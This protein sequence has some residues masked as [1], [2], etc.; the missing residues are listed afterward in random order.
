MGRPEARVSSAESQSAPAGKYRVILRS[1]LLEL[2][3]VVE[4]R[5]ILHVDMDAFFASVEQ[6]DHPELRG[7]PV[8]VGYA[9][10][11]GV[12]AAASY[13]ARTFGCRSAQPMSVALRNCPHA[14]VMPVRFARYGQVSDQV[15]AI[16]ESCSSLVEPLS[17]DEAFM[18]VTAS[19]RLLGEPVQIARRIKA[20]IRAATGL[21]A[22]VGVSCNKFLA[23]LASDLHKPDGLTV[24]AGGEAQRILAPM[25]VTRLWGVGPKTAAQLAGLG[26]KTIGDLLKLPRD[27]LDVRV[28]ADEAEHYRRLAVGADD[29]P[30]VP[31]RESKS[32]GQEQTF[33]ID[34]CDAE[35]VRE[36]MLEQS[37]EVA[38][39]LR[40]HG[41]RARAVVIKIRFGNFQTITRRVTLPEPTD[42]TRQISQTARELFDRWAAKHFQPVRLI[43]V[44]AADLTGAPPQLSL[45]ADEESDRQRTL[46][47]ALDQIGQKFGNDVIRRGIGSL[48]SRTVN[49]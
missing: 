23:K 47:R 22:S 34:V 38:R 10:P 30:V 46:D 20:E 2:P 14:T 1:R 35:Q 31:D 37:A 15:F 27:V 18:D 4:P 9:G 32:I 24:I 42:L 26:V 16:L 19:Q 33:G 7:K 29:R 49:E 21:T 36:V 3:L 48:P 43:G 45:F 11:R 41:L 28:G 39:R 40:R 17:I 13:E 25:P 12:V 5:A 44:T 6:L 8:L